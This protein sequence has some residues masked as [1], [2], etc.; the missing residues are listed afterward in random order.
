MENVRKHNIQHAVYLIFFISLA[1]R[2]WGIWNVSTTDEYNEVI[3]ALRVCSGHFNFE[4]WVK[5][6]YLY[7]LAI[8]YGIYYV[9]GWL[10]NAF[11]SPMGFAEKIVRHM[12]P[13]FI[14][15]RLTSAIVGALTV[16]MVYKIGTKFYNHRV[17]IISSL[18]LTITVFHI[19]LSQQAK[20]DAVLGLLVV[21]AFYFIFKLLEPDESNK[22]DYAWCGF[23]MALAMQTKLNSIVLI[24]PFAI[25]MLYN[26]KNR[27]EFFNYYLWFFTGFFVLGFI[28]GNPPVLLAPFKFL[29]SVSG[30]GKVYTTAI[31]VV[32]NDLI[33]FLAY[34]LYYYRSMGTVVSLLTI[35]SV[36]HALFNLNKR[37]TVLLAFIAAFY[38]LM[39]ASKYM[40]ADYYM[41]PAVPFI[42]LLIGD[43]FNEASKKFVSTKVFLS[44]KTSI[45]FILILIVALIR[46]ALNVAFHELSL[47]GKNTR[48]LAKDW[49]EANIPEGSKVLMD[50]GK[51]INSRAP[52]IAE[53]SETLER[54]LRNAKKNVSEGKIVH[55]MVDKNALIYY[56]LLLKTVPKKSYDIT[57]TMFGLDVKTIDYYISNQYQYLIISKG[58][59]NS[60]TN[61]FFS[62]RNPEIAG[63]YKSLNADKRIRLIKT[64]S[65]TPMNRGGTFYIY[66][67]IT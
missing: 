15:G 62:K 29:K 38:I 31:N 54:I 16:G 60:R 4:R 24:V 37:R 43:F 41:I 23:L 28:I 19:D 12:E 20:V 57:S 40:I 14:L 3:E 32:S 65:P 17:A 36:I 2:L 25:A 13:L 5:R 33:G 26:W 10:F 1:L 34:P 8:E 55:G 63:F 9:I 59:K 35:L 64:I 44:S 53:N 66:E 11:S 48:Y 22:W 49:I 39:G 27:E 67:V 56:E 6:F 47:S 46:P 30:L 58:M 45:V 61:E 51:S 52:S 50:S 7:V 21:G 42:Y 18:L